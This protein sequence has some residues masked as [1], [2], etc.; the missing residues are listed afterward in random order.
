MGGTES[1]IT[2]SRTETIHPQRELLAEGAVT[3]KNDLDRDA[4]IFLSNLAYGAVS[5]GY[6]RHGKSVDLPSLVNVDAYALFED[7][8]GVFVKFKGFATEVTYSKK[9][10]NLTPGQT[11]S[12]SDFD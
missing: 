12:F 11:Y 1:T 3:I 8:S 5:V 9:K 4:L 10:V 6:A 7:G 2:E